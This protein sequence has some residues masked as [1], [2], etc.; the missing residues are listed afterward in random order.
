MFHKSSERW[1]DDEIDFRVTEGY[2][3]KKGEKETIEARVD[4]PMRSYA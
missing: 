2:K 3:Y 4:N 1:T